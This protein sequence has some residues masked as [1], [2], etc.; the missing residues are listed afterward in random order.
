MYIPYGCIFVLVLL[1]ISGT[2]VLAKLL[3]SA[4]NMSPQYSDYYLND[5]DGNGIDDLVPTDVDGGQTEEFY[6]KPLRMPFVQPKE[7]RIFFFFI[8]Q[9]S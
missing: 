7:V 9:T 2:N 8:F 3:L 4:E 6:S 1:S 5:L